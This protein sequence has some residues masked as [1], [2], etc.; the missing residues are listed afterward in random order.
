VV[1]SHF[2]GM[3][4]V[5]DYPVTMPVQVV[6]QPVTGTVGELSL[7]GYSIEQPFTRS[8]TL[9]FHLYWRLTAQP[10]RD[11]VLFMHIY[12]SNGKLIAQDDNP[13]EQGKRSTLTYRPGEGIDQ[14]HRVVMPADAPSGPYRLFAGVYDRAGGARWPAAQ[15]GAAAKDDLLFLGTLDLPDLP[16]VYKVFVPYVVQGQ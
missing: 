15:D 5:K 12:D 9:R 7:L 16:P 1:G 14:I 6:P 2:L 4:E 11:G 10:A 3:V 8:V 13:P